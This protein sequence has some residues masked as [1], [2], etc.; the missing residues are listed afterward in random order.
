MSVKVKAPVFRILRLC[1]PVVNDALR[2]FAAAK[3]LGS[4]GAEKITLSELQQVGLDVGFRIGSVVA[5]EVGRANAD[6]ID[7]EFETES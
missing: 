5:R 2:D 6:I 7:G 1:A 3:S 4:D